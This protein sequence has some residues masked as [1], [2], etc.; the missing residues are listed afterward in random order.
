MRIKKAFQARMLVYSKNRPSSLIDVT[1]PEEL[2]TVEMYLVAIEAI[3][4]RIAFIPHVVDL[5]RSG[6]LIRDLWNQIPIQFTA[7]DTQTVREA[8]NI[9]LAKL[10][11]VGRIREPES[12]A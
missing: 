7:E 9:A 6:T 4:E 5:G 11:Y 12:D 2:I 8:M 3:V 1:I 10:G